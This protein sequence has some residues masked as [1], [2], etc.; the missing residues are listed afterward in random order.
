MKI[1]IKW[2]QY[3]VPSFR[4]L[5]Y[6]QALLKLIGPLVCFFV[7]ARIMVQNNHNKYVIYYTLPKITML[8]D[9]LNSEK[10]KIIYFGCPIWP[11]RDLFNLFFSGANCM[12]CL[13]YILYPASMKNIRRKLLLGQKFLTFSGTYVSDLIS[14]VS[15][16]RAC[17]K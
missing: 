14:K 3:W 2:V 16:W 6:M 1:R 9:T 4:V 13:L 15:A 12:I 8:K 7:E 10:N 11:E 17:V 5:A